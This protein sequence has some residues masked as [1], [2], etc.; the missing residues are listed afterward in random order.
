MNQATKVEMIDPMITK[1]ALQ[2][3]RSKEAVARACQTGK[4][5]EAQAIDAHDMNMANTMAEIA[6]RLDVYAKTLELMQIHTLRVRHAFPQLASTFAEFE[7]I[8]NRAQ[9]VNF[10]QANLDDYLRSQPPQ[11]D[12]ILA[13]I[14]AAQPP[15]YPP[16]L[17]RITGDT[18]ANVRRETGA[19]SVEC[20]TALAMHQ[21]RVRDAIQGIQSQRPHYYGTP[22]V[23]EEARRRIEFAA[24]QYQDEIEHVDVR[25]GSR[26]PDLVLN[27]H[28][29]KTTLPPQQRR[30]AGIDPGPSVMSAAA[31]I[32]AA[33]TPPVSDP[34][35]FEGGGGQSDGGGASGDW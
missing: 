9:A 1:L 34:A 23:M 32:F 31:L 17:W 11:T 16:M 3:S 12:T 30:D 28:T 6:A 14:K 25:S 26:I 2:Y 29:G 22:E 24:R 19:P 21:G 15:I 8:L 13:E 10:D 5:G 4:P 18:V 27:T 20:R 7:R 35:P 33:S